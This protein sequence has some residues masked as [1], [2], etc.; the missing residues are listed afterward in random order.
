MGAAMCM[1]GFISKCRAVCWTLQAS[2]MRMLSMYLA[3][4]ASGALALSVNEFKIA[5]KLWLISAAVSVCVE[6]W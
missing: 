3:V 6:K 2:G 1:P 4:N 5:S